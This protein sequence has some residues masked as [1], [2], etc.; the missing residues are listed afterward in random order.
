MTA[1]A[2]VDR[3]D[4]MIPTLQPGREYTCPNCRAAKFSIPDLVCT[5]CQQ[6]SLF[7]RATA[8]FSTRQALRRQ[9]RAS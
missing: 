2:R 5:S 4:A 1:T 9:E 8:A 7:K 3:F 6:E